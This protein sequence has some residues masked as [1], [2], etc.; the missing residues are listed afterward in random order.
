[1]RRCYSCGQWGHVIAV[2]TNP[3]PP[4]MQEKRNNLKFRSNPNYT[5]EPNHHHSGYA[6][7][8]LNGYRPNG[9]YGSYHPQTQPNYHRF[10]A[11]YNY[12]PEQ[13]HFHSGQ[14]HPIQIISP[15][16]QTQREERK[17]EKLEELYRKIQEIKIVVD[18]IL[19]I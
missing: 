18:D 14:N 15:N 2:C 9:I 10:D 12:G 17:Q 19:R 11:Y 8:G 5:I 3:K 1:M 7:K 4:Q 16:D 6:P 13:Q